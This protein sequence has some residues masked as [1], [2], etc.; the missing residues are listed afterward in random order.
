[1]KFIWKA[2]F[3]Y[4]SRGV[5][6]FASDFVA[7]CQFDSFRT[8]I[9][10]IN[11]LKVEISML[12]ICFWTFL[13]IARYGIFGS[14]LLSFPQNE[15]KVYKLRLSLSDLVYF[16]STEPSMFTLTKYFICTLISLINA[17]LSSLS[18]HT[19][20]LADQ[21]TLFQ[22]GGTDYAHLITTGTPGFS[23]LLTAL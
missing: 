19:Q 9:N 6:I 10:S 5:T 8:N 17:G 2:F 4:W 12:H 22:P 20:I 21:L 13:K 3:T 23:D 18:V 11:G 15:I 16:L 14:Y 1:M 7:T